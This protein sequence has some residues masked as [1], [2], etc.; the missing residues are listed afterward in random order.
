MSA[1]IGQAAEKQAQ[2]FHDT[3][4]VTGVVI[5]KLDGT[6]KGG[7]ALIACA[8]TGAPVRFIGVG[9]KVDDF[10]EFRAQG[11]VGRLLGM[12]DLE[13]LLEKTREAISEEDAEDMGKRFL[14]GEFTLIDLY[15]QMKAMKKMGPLNKVFSMI[16][17]M[18]GL[19]IPKEVLD[20]QEGKIDDWRVLMDSMT[21]SELED[22]S[23]MNPGRIER[24]ANGSGK[25]TR[26]V[27]ELIKQYKQSKKM[28]K[29]M[30]GMSGSE[31]DM[32]KMMAKMQKSGMAKKLR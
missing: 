10:E 12:G 27:R 1:D 32:Q 25:S 5:T 14:K 8:V 24:I 28:A 6:A 9:E 2:T 26:A 16:P 17:G 29:M 23:V 21:R 7:G 15:E 11:F 30:K 18:G 13:S 4:N 31:K 20:M 3:C 22:P 19:D